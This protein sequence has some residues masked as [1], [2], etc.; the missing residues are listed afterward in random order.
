MLNK[1]TF[2]VSI[3]KKE[4]FAMMKLYEN[5]KNRRKELN[6]TQEK[7]AELLGYTSKAMIS[8]VEKGQVD[9]PVSKVEE[10]AA[11]LRTTTYELMGWKILDD[12][13]KRLNLNNEEMDLLNKYRKLNSE[14]KG[15]ITDQIDMY[16]SGPAYKKETAV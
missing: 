3:T 12:S 4:E 1:I 7:L 15:Y 14:H 5:I 8:K 6:M 2:R 13:S 16:L 11:A 10:F 9:L